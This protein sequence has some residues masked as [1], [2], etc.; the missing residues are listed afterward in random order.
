MPTTPAINYI[1]SD[2]ALLRT[3]GRFAFLIEES[4]NFGTHVLE[5]EL[6]ASAQTRENA[7]ISLSM[8]HVLELL[9]I[10]LL[11]ALCHLTQCDLASEL[12]SAM[13]PSHHS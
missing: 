3:L 6:E 11:L 12:F 10:L 2:D 4:V 9:L 13:K 5:W 7:P 8:R 1:P